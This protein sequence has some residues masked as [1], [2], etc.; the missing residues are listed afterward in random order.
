[1]HIEES[2]ILILTLFLIP[3]SLRFYFYFLNLPVHIYLTII[4]I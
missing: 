1:M 3:S 4:I 2:A